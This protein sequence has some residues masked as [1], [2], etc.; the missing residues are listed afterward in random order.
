MKLVYFGTAPFAIPAL[1]ALAPHVR[2]V[3]SQ[4][5][6]PS[7]RG[8]KLRPSPVKAA[9]E[10]LGIEVAAPEKCRAPEFV[11]R[12]RSLGADALVVAA[13]GQILSQAVLDSARRGGIN[14]HGSILPRYR[15]AAPIQRAIQRGETHTGVTLMQ[16][17]RGM[18]T[19]DMIAVAE[20]PIGADDIAGDL[21]ARLAELAAALA[22]EWMP[23]IVVGDYPRTPQEA[24][25]ATLAPKV[26]KAEARLD[27]SGQARAEYDRFRAFTPAPGAYLDLQTGTLRVL[28]ARLEPVDANAGTWLDTSP[29]LLAMKGGAL[30]LLRVQ[31]AGRP[32]MPGADWANGA[33]IRVGETVR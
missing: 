24:E 11:E 5:D 16:M 20:A 7:G 15:G 14:L 9:A 25:L 10:E 6:R 26:E 8:M 23:R 12:L 30:R 13:Y 27:T 18:D 17:D 2:L 32:A 1:Q 3:V 22:Y 28:A 4:P 31:P 19:G 21:T 33:R 29:P